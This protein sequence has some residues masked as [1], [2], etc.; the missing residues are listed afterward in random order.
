MATAPCGAP[1]D[2]SDGRHR[3]GR[4]GDRAETLAQWHQ[5]ILGHT[6]EHGDSR[7]R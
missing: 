4:R 7:S 5:R 6:V 1:A 3:E 2:D